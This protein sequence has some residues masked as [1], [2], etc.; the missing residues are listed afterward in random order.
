MTDVQALQRVEDHAPLIIKFAQLARGRLMSDAS[1]MY[2]GLF[3]QLPQ[4]WMRGDSGLIETRTESLRCAHALTHPDLDVAV[5]AVEHETGVEFLAMG[6]GG[7]L[8]AHAA[9]TLVQGMWS[10]WTAQRD[11]TPH[12]PVESSLVLEGVRE[13]SADGH[14]RT[15]VRMVVSPPLSADEIPELMRRFRREFP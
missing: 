1:A 14:V 9:Q 15:V 2:D 13:A 11:R 5:V 3:D 7:P 10:Q 4:G 6:V 8:V 12:L